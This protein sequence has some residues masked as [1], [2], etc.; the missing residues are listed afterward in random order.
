MPTELNNLVNMV[1]KLGDWV[2]TIWNFHIVAS[3]AILG[4]LFTHR[5]NWNIKQKL[6][7]T[8]VYISFVFTNLLSQIEIHALLGAALKELR[9]VLA[10]S[11]FKTED[12]NKAIQNYP[13]MST[14]KI[15]AVHL[16]A[17]LAVLLC[18]W[19]NL[20]KREAEKNTKP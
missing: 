5:Q 14:L 16:V 9:T 12:L 19:T 2:N 17:D 20:V 10:Q 15:I 7:L 18:L 3:V 1:F 8:I 4:W 11:P 6:I 13:Q